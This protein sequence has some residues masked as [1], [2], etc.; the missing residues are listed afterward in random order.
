[1]LRSSRPHQEADGGHLTPGGKSG[2][3]SGDRITKCFY[4]GEKT[5]VL[6]RV[7]TFAQAL[8]KDEWGS[9]KWEYVSNS[10]NLENN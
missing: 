4:N 2:S 10:D 6:R 3:S 7:S 8:H 5:R 9:T 1:L